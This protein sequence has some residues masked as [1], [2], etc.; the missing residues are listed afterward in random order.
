MKLVTYSFAAYIRVNGDFRQ[1]A[2]NSVE[3]FAE[4]VPSKGSEIALSLNDMNK[5]DSP[6]RANLRDVAK[7]AGV[8]VATVSRVMNM[9]E[10]VAETTRLRVQQV[11]EDLRFRPSAAARAI[12]SGR[13]RIVGALTPTMDN[14]IFARFLDGLEGQLAAA[15]LSLVVSTT[16]DDPVVELRKAKELLNIGAE[17]LVVSGVTHSPEFMSLIERER[18][19][20][21]AISY[22][23]TGFSFPTVGYDNAE[24]VTMALAHL[25]ELGHRDIAVIHGLT[26]NN[27]RTRARL[28][29]IRETVLPVRLH[30]F[31]EPI[32]V[33]GGCRAVSRIVG[34][35]PECTGYL[36]FSD[37]LA[38]GALFEA[39]R[40]GL[41]VPGDVSIMGMEGLPLTEHLSPS[42]TTIDLSVYE[43]GV[44]TA[45]ALAQWV[46]N[47]QRPENQRMP[48][49]LIKRES[50]AAAPR[51]GT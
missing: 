40:Q 2:C 16:D 49:R 35:H 27:D 32:D 25:F 37:V 38:M 24:A 15:D 13:T 50:T 11:I 9:P 12:N 19:P 42:L 1:N 7:A 46:N 8:S 4:T 26:L 34:E 29:A 10:Q 41:N 6:K 14:A 21:V 45:A 5:F 20:I 36:C 22:A 17:G 44:G 3:S 47:R 30:F 18:L 23:E 28:N 39:Q 33:E 51:K 31:E 43:M 48:I